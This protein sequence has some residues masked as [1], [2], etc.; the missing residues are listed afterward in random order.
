M[1][2]GVFKQQKSLQFLAVF[3]L[4]SVGKVQ[5][6][7][8]LIQQASWHSAFIKIARSELKSH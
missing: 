5:K 2:S 7:E 3:A 8:P 6:P 4:H 1:T